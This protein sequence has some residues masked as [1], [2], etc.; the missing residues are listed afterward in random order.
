MNNKTTKKIAYRLNEESIQH[1]KQ[2][3]NGTYR[4]N[5]HNCKTL[6]K[7]RKDHTLKC[8]LHK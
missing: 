7:L 4:P 1:Y 6:Q 2:H 8:A 3:R 5:C